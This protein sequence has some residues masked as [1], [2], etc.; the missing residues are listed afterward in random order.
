MILI[1][2]IIQVEI[3]FKVIGSEKW[4]FKKSQREERY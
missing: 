1:A 4:C 2:I 3:E